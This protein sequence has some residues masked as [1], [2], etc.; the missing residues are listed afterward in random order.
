MNKIIILFLFLIEINLIN[1]S[2]NENNNEDEI[3][4]FDKMKYE[5]NIESNDYYEILIADHMI[6]LIEN[7]TNNCNKIE[8]SECQKKCYQYLNV[9][10]ETI[11]MDKPICKD[12]INDFYKNSPNP[13]KLMSETL[14]KLLPQEIKIKKGDYA[15][16]GKYGSESQYGPNGKNGPFG[17]YGEKGPFRT[18]KHKFLKYGKIKEKICNFIFQKY[19]LFKFLDRVFGRLN[20]IKTINRICG[21]NINYQRRLVEAV[22]DKVKICEYLFGFFGFDTSSCGD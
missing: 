7:I 2:T 9:I 16:K 8:K 12:I 11:E 3:E 15:P 20:I 1:S 4:F 18:H 21:S 6:E 5:V 13:K 19:E 22:I 17:P 14:T 10:N